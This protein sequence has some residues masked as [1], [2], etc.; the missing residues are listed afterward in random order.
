MKK[1][2]LAAFVT[3]LFSSAAFA[4]SGKQNTG[5]GLGTVLW[6]GK[7]DGSIVS[8]AFQATTNG[9]FWQPDLRHHLR[10]LGVRHAAQLRPE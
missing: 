8:Q 9:T 2:V 6:N 3:L 10:H 5:C 7:A 1:I 4:A